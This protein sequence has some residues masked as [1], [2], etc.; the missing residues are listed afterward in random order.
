MR[1]LH[2]KDVGFVDATGVTIAMTRQYGRAPKGERVHASAPVH[3]GQNVT[4]LGALSCDGLRAA[5]TLDGS[6][7]AQAF[8]TFVQ[9]I[10]VPRWRPGPIVMRDNR[11]S[12]KVNGVQEAIEAVGAPL[13]YCPSY[14]PDVAP[15]EACWSKCKALLRAKAA[16][17][18]ER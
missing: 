18:R 6:T 16:R 13:E 14:S 17:T 9:T 1:P 2:S 12:H 3:N 15:I 10:L 7:D 4:L 8:V 11:A 5:M